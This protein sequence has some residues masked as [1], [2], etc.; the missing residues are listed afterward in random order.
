MIEISGFSFYC[1][2]QGEGFLKI[3]N[4]LPTKFKILGADPLPLPLP[5]PSPPPFL[6]IPKS[7]LDRHPEISLK[8]NSARFRV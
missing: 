6:E 1:L 4:T 8:R 7:C 3:Y 5:L 2:S